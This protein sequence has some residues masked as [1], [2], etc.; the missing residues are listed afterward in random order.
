MTKNEIPW[1]LNVA[2]STDAKKLADGITV[3]DMKTALAQL[4][5]GRRRQRRRPKVSAADVRDAAI[6]ISTGFFFGGESERALAVRV[7][8]SDAQLSRIFRDRLAD[9]FEDWGNL[10]VVVRPRPRGRRRSVAHEWATAY[11]I[12]NLKRERPGKFEAIVS[13]VMART[14]LKRTQVLDHWKKHRR[15]FGG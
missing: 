2:T 11:M 4:R 14:G 7:L 15:L 5:G 9:M 1:S 10:R 12:A 3:A 6:A 8:Q 13:E